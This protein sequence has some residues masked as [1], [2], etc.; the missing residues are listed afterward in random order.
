[1]FLDRAQSLELHGIFQ[2][3]PKPI[4]PFWWGKSPENPHETRDFASEKN[5]DF[6]VTSVKSLLVMV[7]SL[8]FSLR[9]PRILHD[10]PR[11]KNSHLATSIS[12]D[13]KNPTFFLR[14]ISIFRWLNDT[15][16]LRCHLQ[17]SLTTVSVPR[18]RF[19]QIGVPPN[20]PFEWHFPLYSLYSGVP[21]FM[22]SPNGEMKIYAYPRG[23]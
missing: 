4:P 18:W 12:L 8:F 6:L 15:G 13:Q 14:D 10:I 3:Y 20:H 9:F 23:L 16:T 1:M 11:W 2:R 21:P 5:H 7:K 19:P 22:E 17:V